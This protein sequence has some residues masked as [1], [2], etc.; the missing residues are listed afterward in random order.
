MLTAFARSGLPGT[1]HYT[2]DII[3]VTLSL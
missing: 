3:H 2:G 1:Q